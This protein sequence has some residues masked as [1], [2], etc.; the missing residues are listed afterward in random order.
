MHVLFEDDGQLRA[1]SVLADNDSSLQVEAAS[2]KRLKIK[3]GSVLLRFAAPSPSVLLAEAQRLASE[4]DPQFLWD[5]STDDEFGFAEL[6]RDYYGHPPQPAEASAIALVLQGSPM[7]FYKRGKGRYRRAPE[8]SV[9]AALASVQRKAREGEQAKGWMDELAA[10]RLPEAFR[11]RLPMLLHRPDK[12]SL[13]W[14][15]LSR[16]C[17]AL[18]TNLVALLAACGAI[19][20]S[21]EYHYQAFLASAFPQGTSFGSPGALAPLPELAVADVRAFSIDDVTTTEIDDAFSVQ[22]LDGGGFRIGIHI[23][24]PAL[25][26]ARGSA[27]DEIA[28]NRLSTVYMP[29][30]KITMLPEPVI[31]AFTLLAGDAPPALSLFVDVSQDGRPLRHE[32]R[33]ER[34]PIAANLHLSALDES[35][36]REPRADDAPWTA[37]LRALWRLAQALFEARG[38]PD[39][40][41]TDY[42]FYVDW[43]AAPEGRVTIVPRPRGSPLDKLIA[44]LM[45]HVNSTWGRLLADARVA[46]LYRTQGNGK[47]KM[48]TRASQHQGLGVS[49]YL[50]ASSPLR[51]YADLLN[52]RQIIAVVQGVKPPYAD[53]DAELFGTLADFE[54]T[55]A[56]YAEFQAR[57]E[58]YWCLRWLLQESVTET[59]GT[60]LRESLVRLEALPLTVRLADMP[61]LPV[62]TRV[63]VAIGRIDLL[64]ATME[65]RYAGPV[66][67]ARQPTDAR[68]ES[69]FGSMQPS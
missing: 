59:T 25:G 55:Y 6:A 49:H 68:E 17:E 12:Q 62:D 11:A 28:R 50:W 1:G 51:R 63:R 21:H 10:H 20:S 31:D 42:S 64:A 58:H 19:P 45:I 65:C 33:V 23:A 44:E 26:I 40:T 41:R 36:T 27:L 69:A 22:A 29:G 57:M 52:Q 8:A 61:A 60:V 9:K 56:S 5:V 7:F 2:G 38:K 54:A 4:L 47:V 34:V 24:A 66:E 18:H 16:A 15:A 67:Q 3:L 13:E 43:D 30:R 46:G 32:T 48:S 35:F 14:K 39:F 37:E 53:N